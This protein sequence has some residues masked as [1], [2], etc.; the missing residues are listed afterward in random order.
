MTQTDKEL[1]E[2]IIRI[3]P[4]EGAAMYLLYEKYTPKFK[5]LYKRIFC[6]DMSWYEDCINDLFAYLKG[7]NQDWQTF[8]TFRWDS[9]FSTWI[10]GVARNRFLDMKPYLIGKIENPLSIDDNENGK[11]P[12]ELPD[13]YL[14][15]YERRQRK[16]L[17]MEAVGLLKDMDQKFVILKTLQGYSSAEIADLLNQKWQ[18]DGIKKYDNK[19]KLVVPT[20]GYVD[21]RRQRAK[22]QLKRIIVEL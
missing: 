6:Q 19:G 15:D 2:A 8:R 20:P 5:K 18:K 14:E 7:K 9:K 21:V 4:D 11:K 3:P 13:E 12:V 22:E 16:V 10:G 1:V 17:L